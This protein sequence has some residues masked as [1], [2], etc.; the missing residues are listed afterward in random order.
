MHSQII[1]NARHPGTSGKCSTAEPL[2][3]REHATSS[4]AE[5]KGFDADSHACPLFTNT[6]SPKDTSDKQELFDYLETKTRRR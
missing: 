6:F 3:F 5:M 1:H 2:H 4:R